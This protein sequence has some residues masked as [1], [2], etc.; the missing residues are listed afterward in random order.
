MWR[1]GV[2]VTGLFL[3]RTVSASDAGTTAFAMLKMPYNAREIAMAGASVAVPSGLYGVQ[4]NPSN[5]GFESGIQAFTGYR[6]VV[7]DTWGGIAGFG[8]RVPGA[9]FFAVQVFDN[10]GGTL[11]ELNRAGEKTGV[12]WKANTFAGG[13]SWGRIV[14][15]NLA[16]GIAAKGTYDYIGGGDE[17]YSAGGLMLDAG[18]QYRLFKER[19][20][21]G[22]VVQ[23]AGVMVKPYVAGDPYPLPLT[24]GLGLSFVPRY[25]PNLRFALDAQKARGEVLTFEPGVAVALAN[26]V[27]VVRGGFPFSVQE[28][29]QLV[30]TM[31]GTG[32]D[33]YQMEN[34]RMLCLGIGINTA[35]GNMGLGIDAAVEFHT[36]LQPSLAI[37]MLFSM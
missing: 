9:G 16:I 33:F 6:S 7:L 5:A 36:E 35:F 11:E 26:D 24:A 31:G 3:W 13:L 8:M 34:W 29:S 25:M 18:M 23:N 14:Y 4:A 27:F 15:P 2:L 22:A 1:L 32:D 12:T 30:K 20:V 37:S 17:V 21:V 28:L 10:S 19:L